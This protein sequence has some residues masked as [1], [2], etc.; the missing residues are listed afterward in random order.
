MCGS[1]LSFYSNLEPCCLWSS[2]SL[3]SRFINSVAIAAVFIRCSFGVLQSVEIVSCS[4][5]NCSEVM[6]LMSSF[7]FLLQNEFFGVT[8]A[9]FSWVCL[10]PLFCS[11][12]VSVLLFRKLIAYDHIPP[13]S[14]CRF[15]F[16]M[17]SLLLLLF[18]RIDQIGIL[19]VFEVEATPYILIC[20]SG[21]PLFFSYSPACVEWVDLSRADFS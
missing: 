1:G 15:F 14:S 10:I 21:V 9:P 13:S 16:S 3:L 6:V 8:I 20:G 12:S 2:P 18:L 4:G 7:F 5:A 19:F 11:E 17:R